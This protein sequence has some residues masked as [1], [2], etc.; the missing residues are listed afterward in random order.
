MGTLHK[1]ALPVQLVEKTEPVLDTWCLCEQQGMPSF[2]FFF[3]LYK[4]ES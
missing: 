3:H 4:R 1:A 2:C